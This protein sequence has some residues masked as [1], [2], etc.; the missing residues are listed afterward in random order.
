MKILRKLYRWTRKISLHFGRH[1]QLDHEGPKTG[2]LFLLTVCC[3]SL[4]QPAT[5][6]AGVVCS[7]LK[8]MTSLTKLVP[9]LYINSDGRGSSLWRIWERDRLQNFTRIYMYKNVRCLKLWIKVC[10]CT[11]SKGWSDQGMKRML[12]SWS[13]WWTFLVFYLCTVAVNVSGLRLT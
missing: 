7:R 4:D 9:E 2:K 5:P 8:L 10:H 12:D 6:F 13:R 11:V 1:P 3:L